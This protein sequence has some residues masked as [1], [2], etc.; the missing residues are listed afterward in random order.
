MGFNGKNVL[1]PDGF[2]QFEVG[3]GT[4]ADLCG[5]SDLVGIAG[6]GLGRNGESPVFKADRVRSSEDDAFSLRFLFTA[7]R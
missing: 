1:A 6:C 4:V 3:T 7:P 5:E 2:D